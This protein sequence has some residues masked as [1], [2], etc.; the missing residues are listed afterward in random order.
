MIT[1]I[2]NFSNKTLKDVMIEKLYKKIIIAKMNNIKMNEFTNENFKLMRSD[3]NDFFM[4]LIKQTKIMK[5]LGEIINT[6]F[7]KTSL[8]SF[9]DIM[10]TVNKQINFFIKFFFS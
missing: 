5:N 10:E 1:E 7:D 6:F 2:K 4:E 8:V 9:D 3:L